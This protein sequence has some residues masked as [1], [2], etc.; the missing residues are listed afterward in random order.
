MNIADL[1]FEPVSLGKR[2]FVSYKR[3]D[4]DRVAPIAKCLHELGVP[5]W[6]DKG[7][8]GGT[9][10]DEYIS[11]EISKADTL[12]MIVFVTRNIFGGDPQSKNYVKREYDLADK[13]KLPIYPIWL[14][15]FDHSDVENTGLYL[16]YSDLDYKEGVKN[17]DVAADEMAWLALKK[18]NLVYKTDALI[19]VAY[20]FLGEADFAAGKECLDFVLKKE[21]ENALAYCG[22]LMAEY[23]VTRIEGLAECGTPL[24]ESDN[25]R[26]AVNI[27][28]KE[29]A[30]ALQEYNNGI[31]KR[32]EERHREEN[33]RKALNLM[34]DARLERD[35]RKAAD[36]FQSLGEY[37]DAVVLAKKCMDDAEIARKAS[38]A[39]RTSKSISQTSDEHGAQKR[40]RTESSA[41][42]T[43]TSIPRRTSLGS[44]IPL[45]NRN[46][47]VR[48]L[49][50]CIVIG[51]VIGKV[52][53][54]QINEKRRQD[55]LNSITEKKQVAFDRAVSH[56][57]KGDYESAYNLLVGLDYADSEW[58][59]SA[60]SCWKKPQHQASRLEPGSYYVFGAYEQ[61]NDL[62][63]GKEDI[64]WLVLAREENRVLVISRYALDAKPYNEELESVTW[65]TCSLRKWLNES[66]LAEAFSDVEQ[67]MIQSVT[68][69]ADPNPDYDTEP[70][71]DTVDKVFLLSISEAK[72]YLDSDDK[73]KCIPTAYAIDN[74]AYASYDATGWWWLR[75]PGSK[76]FSAACVDYVGDVYESGN[77]VSLSSVSVRPALWLNL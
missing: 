57:E 63:N 54:P 14:E 52:V 64:E 70:G 34:K 65:E 73:R 17:A 69:T 29:L 55:E 19:G 24:E 4:S 10:W 45:K 2:Y 67:E 5:L 22:K 60:I 53:L 76:S 61:D 66:F 9:N 43:H 16:W 30:D 50:V 15:D 62:E 75:S 39:A 37:E 42:K 25:Y 47:I 51:I 48:L 31:K 21:P 40:R 1:G 77:F 6:Y 72:L 58:L 38:A 7:I 36:L 41:R 8:E 35:Y 71:N 56:V 28:G 33:Y 3:T 59:R 46:I 32:N 74:G 49:A 18:F 23:R 44:Y 68:V 12:G 20:R 11:A 27:G 26:K 13:M